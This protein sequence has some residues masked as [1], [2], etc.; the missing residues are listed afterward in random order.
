MGQAGVGV[1]EC[2]VL[3][4]IGCIECGADNDDCVSGV[5]LEESEARAALEARYAEH[6]AYVQR[7]NKRAEERNLGWRL[8][9]GDK[10]E[11]GFSVSDFQ[12]RLCRAEIDSEPSNE[13]GDA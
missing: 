3:V 13:T 5:F 1:A 8:R 7:E 9:P 2:W 6:V 4:E 11:F 10:D 12:V